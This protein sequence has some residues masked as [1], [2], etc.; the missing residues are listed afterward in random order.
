MR[1]GGQR[2]VP[3]TLPPGMTRYTLYGR[4]GRP[5]GQSGRVLKISPPPGFDPQTVQLVASRY[6]DYA[7]PAQGLHISHVL[8][9]I[10]GSNTKGAYETKVNKQNKKLYLCVAIWCF[11]SL[12]LFALFCFLFQLCH[13]STLDRLQVTVLLGGWT[14]QEGDIFLEKEY[15]FRN[16]YTFCG[17]RVLEFL[18]SEKYV[19]LGYYIGSLGGQF[20][21][22]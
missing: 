2:H 22:F 18:K 20:L 16:P 9:I 13:S 11:A 17:V 14:L 1:V 6:T 4:V 12:T 5:Q 8:C 21:W 19:L 15:T 3:A 7:I 10:Q